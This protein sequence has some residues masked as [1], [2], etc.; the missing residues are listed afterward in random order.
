M[1]RHTSSRGA[2]AD[3][4]PLAQAAIRIT[5]SSRSQLAVWTVP[6]PPKGRL[7]VL[8]SARTHR[9]VYLGERPPGLHRGAERR[10]GTGCRPSYDAAK[11]GDLAIVACSP[12]S[13]HISLLHR[14]HPVPCRQ[15][16]RELPSKMP[17]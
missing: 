15:K 10:R 2:S 11:M 8:P 17:Y 3:I 13:V 7:K 6:H 9:P 14:N 16:Q 4:S 12:E 1:G 5:Y